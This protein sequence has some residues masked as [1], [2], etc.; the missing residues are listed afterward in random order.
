MTSVRQST[1]CALP[2][3]ETSAAS[4]IEVSDSPKETAAP[5]DIIAIV[6]RGLS[7]ALQAF[8]EHVD[9][10]LQEMKTDICNLQK[11]NQALHEHIAATSN[12]F[13]QRFNE[14]AEVN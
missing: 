10:V 6:Q 2:R 12:V 5:H 9:K 3:V 7:A 4:T 11:S 8:G 13:A 1:E 14:L